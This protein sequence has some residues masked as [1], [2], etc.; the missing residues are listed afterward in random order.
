[1]LIIITL[2]ARYARNILRER[3]SGNDVS[4][5]VFSPSDLYTF[6][7]HRTDKRGETPA[8]LQDYRGGELENLRPPMSEKCVFQ[9]VPTAI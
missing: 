2:T 9:R 3:G 7:R 4:A 5:V 1:M 6:M 8:L